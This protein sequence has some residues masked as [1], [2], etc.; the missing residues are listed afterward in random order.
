VIRKASNAF[1][2]LENNSYTIDRMNV[3]PKIKKNPKLFLNQNITTFTS[4]YLPL[5]KFFKL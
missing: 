3:T 5:N 1:N 4:D 2:S